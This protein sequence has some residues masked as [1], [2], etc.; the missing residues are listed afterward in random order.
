MLEGGNGRREEEKVRHR[1]AE[2]QKRID[3]IMTVKESQLLRPFIHPLLPSEIL[4]GGTGCGCEFKGEVLTSRTDAFAQP[5]LEP[6]V[7][8]H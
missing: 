4:F 3:D 8:C 5:S 6:F 2:W 7:V 1:C